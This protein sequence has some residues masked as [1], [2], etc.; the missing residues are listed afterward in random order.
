M[1]IENRR[2]LHVISTG[3]QSREVLVEI[4]KTIHPYID[5]LHIRERS[6]TAG[7][8]IE[9]VDELT[10]AGIP[11]RKLCIHDRADIAWMKHVRGVQLS[12]HSAPVAHVK[13][14]FPSLKVGSSVHSMQ[15]A[16]WACDEGADFLLYGNIYETT[17]KPGKQ[18][19]GII[20][21]EDIVL[22]IPLPII[23]IGGITPG[24]VEGILRTGAKGIA[25]LSGI[26]LSEDPLEAARAYYMAIHKE[27]KQLGES[28]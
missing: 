9:T 7:E 19:T 11:L 23:A 1:E 24:R 21:L 4:S 15:E 16:L 27:V 10:A 18:G 3:Q 20:N 8:L 22:N 26:F 13:E 25:V 5:M 6:W 2:R 17:S 12:Q 28:I 14:R